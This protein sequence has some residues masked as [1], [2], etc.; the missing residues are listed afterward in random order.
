[1]PGLVCGSDALNMTYTD[2]KVTNGTSY[3]YQIISKNPS[4]QSIASPASASVTPAETLSA[5]APSSPTAL[6]VGSSGHHSVVLN[7]T[8]SDGA[9]Y[10]RV[11]RSTLH[12]NG[13]GAFY[14][15]GTIMLNDQVKGTSFTDSTPTDGKRYRYDVE[16]VSAA[17]ISGR[18]NSVDAQ[19][20]PHPPASAPQSL[21]GDWSKTR[22][23]L[24]IT[25]KWSP[26]PGATGYVIYRSNQKNQFQWPENF[27]TPLLETTWTDTNRGKK[28]NEKKGDDHMDPAKD[29]YYQVTAINAG[30]ISPS[31]TVHI[32]P[33]AK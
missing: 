16:A 6:Q 10:Y 24:G 30:G 9:N 2:T 31:A 33:E 15:L 26:V 27:V 1:M 13:V 5:S 4:G 7:W 11:W 14:P 12:G 3:Y 25:L 22:Q 23:G 32:S 28:K 17:G 21:V 29:F 8:A 20:L 18:S 19:P